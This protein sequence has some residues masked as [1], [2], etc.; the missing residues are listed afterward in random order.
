MTRFWCGA[1][2]GCGALDFPSPSGR[3][4]CSK[5]SIP[6]IWPPLTTVHQPLKTIGYRRCRDGRIEYQ[7]QQGNYWSDTS[8][9]RNCRSQSRLA[10][11]HRRVSGVA[12][13]Y[14]AFSPSLPARKPSRI[15]Q[16]ASRS[17][18]QAGLTKFKLYPGRSRTVP[19]RGYFPLGNSNWKRAQ[20]L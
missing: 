4:V 13:T 11:K 12:R 2:P 20:P 19:G 15:W 10:A 3:Q 9:V 1:R 6:C 17:S 5:K 14:H 8:T 18:S 16:E 7:G